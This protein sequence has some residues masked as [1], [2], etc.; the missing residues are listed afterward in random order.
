MTKGEIK[1]GII[2]CGAINAAHLK[3]LPILD[4]GLNGR[5]EPS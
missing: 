2:G 1:V 3:R 4:M 5:I